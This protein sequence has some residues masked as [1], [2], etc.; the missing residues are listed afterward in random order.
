MLAMTFI[1]SDVVSYVKTGIFDR[2]IGFGFAGMHLWQTFIQASIPWRINSAR[3]KIRSAK[4]SCLL[5][6]CERNDS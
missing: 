6:T 3:P 4:R 2:L 1:I 5:N